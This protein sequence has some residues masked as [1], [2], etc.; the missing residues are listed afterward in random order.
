[1]ILGIIIL[2]VVSTVCVFMTVSFLVAIFGGG[3]FVP[4]PLPAVHKV[5]KHAKI[6][7]GDKV[8]D[9]GA[10]DGRFVH[11]AAKDYGANA[12]GF[13]IDPFVYFIARLRQIFWKWKG[14]M[15][16]SNFQKHDLADAD[17]LLC[18]MMPNTLKKFQK[19]F[20]AQLRKGA[21]VVSYAF[22]VGDWK[23]KKVI[24]RQGKI[25]RIYIYQI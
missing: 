2:I 10:G 3:P 1:M 23:P 25:G 14:K 18:Y 4:T 15:V 21:K 17:V 6:K 7:K 5:L 12:T 9:I 16:R 20:D 19:Q 22:K 24:P 11:F 13:E 8:Y